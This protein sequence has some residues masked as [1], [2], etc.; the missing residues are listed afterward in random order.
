MGKK[1]KGELQ[2]LRKNAV[3][4]FLPPKIK[5]LAGD[6]QLMERRYPIFTFRNVDRDGEFAFDP[7][8]KD[9][10]SKLFIEKLISYSSMT[11]QQIMQQTHDD[12]KSK[13]HFLSPKSLSKKALE[14]I[15]KRRLTDIDSLFSLALTNKTRVIGLRDGAE[16]QIIWYDAEHDFA[17]SVKRNT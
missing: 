11:W 10:D 17:V 13:N 14:R 2:P 5:Q 3:E 16:F 1:L 6:Y 8:R 9:F 15:E 4:N 7:A 12:G